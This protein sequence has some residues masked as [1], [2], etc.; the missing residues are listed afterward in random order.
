MRFSRGGTVTTP[1][2]RAVSA[3][4]VGAALL[5]PLVAGPAAAAD[6]P[7][8]R[9]EG[10]QVYDD[11]LLGDALKP[12]AQQLVDLMAQLHDVDVIVIARH[13]D[14]TVPD[15]DA[16]ATA[17]AKATVDDW[18]LDHAVVLVAEA[19]PDD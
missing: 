4:L 16:D 11:G 8:D 3:A 15:P 5:L 17:T 10:Q 19:G 9:V 18:G 13:R 12:T 2:L 6:P 14:A 1:F 7:P